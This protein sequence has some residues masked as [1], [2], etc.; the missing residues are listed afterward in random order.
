M[1]KKDKKS[2]KKDDKKDEKKDDKKD[3]KED[4]MEEEQK[5]KIELKKKTRMS[6]VKYTSNMKDVIDNAKR[7]EELTAI[8]GRMGFKDKLIRET[9]TTKNKLESYIY[10]ARDKLA[11]EW[12]AFATDKETA[13]IMDVAQKTEDWLYDEGEDVTKDEYLIKHENLDKVVKVVKLRMEMFLTLR[14]MLDYATQRFDYFANEI[15][16]NAEKYAHLTPEDQ[17]EILLNISQSREI[18]EV[19]RQKLQKTTLNVTP[20]VE[21]TQL[22]TSLQTCEKACEVI[23]KKPKPAPVKVEE[24]KDEKKMDEENLNGKTEETKTSEDNKEANG[25]TVNEPKEV[26]QQNPN[27]DVE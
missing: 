5:F 21:L 6:E 4:K 26:P 7:T 11:G 19:A 3:D 15:P 24:K 14:Q 20:P 9:L 2:E 25:A 12:K 27:M 22:Q 16:N 13:D 8:E 23:L 1:T 17:Q 10:D 18:F